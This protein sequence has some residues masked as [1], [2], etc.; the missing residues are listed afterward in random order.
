MPPQIYVAAFLSM[1]KTIRDIGVTAPIYIA[2]ATRCGDHTSEAI[3]DAQ[4]SL[5][6]LQPGLRAGPD[7]DALVGA[8]VRDGCHLTG[9][10]LLR[11]AALWRDVLADDIPYLVGQNAGRDLVR[12]S[13]D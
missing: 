4:R 12:H 3:R 13:N 6:T 7:T 10:G 9:L 8:D 1:V 2:R 5:A 11:H